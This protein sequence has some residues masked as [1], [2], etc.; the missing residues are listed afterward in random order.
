[1]KRMLDLLESGWQI[2]YSKEFKNF[3]DGKEMEFL[4]G[5]LGDKF[6]GKT[7]LLNNLFNKK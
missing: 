3:L 1:M 6:S 7:F 4:I 5:I 2:F